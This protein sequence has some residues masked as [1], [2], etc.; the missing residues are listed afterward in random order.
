MKE[1]WDDVQGIPALVAMGRLIDLTF[2][3]HGISRSEYTVH[4]EDDPS[5]PVLSSRFAINSCTALCMI[6]DFLSIS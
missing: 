6:S 2:E 4:T 5:D 3:L 1:L